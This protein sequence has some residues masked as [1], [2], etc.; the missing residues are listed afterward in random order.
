MTPL[1]DSHQE[2]SPT[3]PPSAFPLTLSPS[4][5]PL[6][7]PCSF[8]NSHPIH[9]LFPLLSYFLT[10]SYRLSP[11]LFMTIT[12]SPHPSPFLLIPSPFFFLL[13]L[14]VLP[15]HGFPSPLPLLLTTLTFPLSL[16]PPSTLPLPNP[17]LPSFLHFPLPYLLSISHS[18]F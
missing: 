5:S 17:F 1:E 3:L 18:S 9:S 4:L 12:R 2:T 7:P 6:T 15:P 14:S 10:F 11:L 8:L 16:L 13:P